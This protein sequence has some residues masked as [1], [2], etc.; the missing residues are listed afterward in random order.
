ML[1]CLVF[2]N[3]CRVLRLSWWLM[4]ESKIN[5]VNIVL[6]TFSNL[7]R[8]SIYRWR[9]RLSAVVN[10]QA[11]IEVPGLEPIHSSGEFDHMYINQNAAGCTFLPWDY[12]VII[13]TYFSCD[14]FTA[15]PRVKNN[16]RAREHASCGIVQIL[17]ILQ[18]F[19]FSYPSA[20]ELTSISFLYEGFS[21]SLFLSRP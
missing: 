13:I 8:G 12:L 1:F 5:I 18:I 14:L 10:A 4:S 17:Q 9:M 2:N 16:R 20:L 11:A 15:L 7:S 6:A 21:A 3:I 19:F